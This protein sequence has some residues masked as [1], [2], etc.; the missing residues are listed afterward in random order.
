M[1][2]HPAPS[3]RIHHDHHTASG[4]RAR[5]RGAPIAAAGGVLAFIDPRVAAASEQPGVVA[6]D[7]QRDGLRQIADR[8]AMTPGVQAIVLMTGVLTEWT[9]L[10]GQITAL[11]QIGRALGPEGVLLLHGRAVAEN[12]EMIEEMTRLARIR[13]VGLPDMLTAG[14]PM[15]GDEDAAD[16]WVSPRRLRA[17]A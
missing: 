14:A 15:G 8:L 17:D 3:V 11:R 4:R 12:P 13:V 1:Q 5:R 7:P 10:P 2:S 16:P 9:A 6:L